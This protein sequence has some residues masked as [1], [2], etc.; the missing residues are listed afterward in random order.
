M[1]PCGNLVYLVYRFVTCLFIAKE[2]LQLHHISEE[3]ALPQTHIYCSFEQ[4]IFLDFEFDYFTELIWL[5]VTL[6]MFLFVA[7]DC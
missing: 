1:W 5:R 4:R 3:K 6:K 2:S 7:R